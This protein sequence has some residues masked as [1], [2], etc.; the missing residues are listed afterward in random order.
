V[1]VIEWISENT[2]WARPE[3]LT[4]EVEEVPDDSDLR[5]GLVF[6]EVRDGYAKWAHLRCPKCSEHIQLPLAGK[7]SWRIEYDWLRRPTI[8]PSIWQTGSCGAHFF[9]RR[10]Q[11]VWCVDL[12]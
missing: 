10:G 5:G 4:I 7:P 6:H 9:I 3:F 2:R 8:S 1:R 12:S 11:V